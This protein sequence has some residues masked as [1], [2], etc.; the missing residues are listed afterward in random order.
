VSGGCVGVGGHLS[1]LAAVGVGAGALC[2]AG[3]P[4]EQLG[5]AGQERSPAGGSVLGGA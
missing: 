3:D 4:G 1:D 2:A 5:L